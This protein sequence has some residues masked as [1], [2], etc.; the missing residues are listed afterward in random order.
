MASTVAIKKLPKSQI[1]LEGEIPAADF[2]RAVLRSLREWNEKAEIP[3]FRSGKIPENILVEKIGMSA[4]LERAAELALGDAYPK[5][6]DEQKID[7]VGQPAVTITKM[8]RG[9]ALGFK[10]ITAVVPDVALPDD[11]KTIAQ[12]AAAKNT[13]PVS[14]EEKD[15]EDA[16]DYLR[17]ANTP[18]ETPDKKPGLD[19]AF[20]QKV[21]QATL[22]D[23][24]NL[25][26]QNI[27]TDKERKA[28]DKKRMASLDAVASATIIEIPDALIDGE[29]K[30]MTEELKHSI[31]DMGLPWDDYLKH[32][33]KTESDL[34]SEWKPEAE[35][36]VRY[37]LVIRAI[38]EREHIEPSEADVGAHVEKMLARY[39]EPERAQIDKARL[40]VYA[41]GILRNEKVFELLEKS[42]P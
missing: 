39:P 16:L 3:G 14:V 41:Y 23:L 26:A 28:A 17:S 21:G 8:A 35:R 25:L 33:K 34:V 5:I 6:L 30:K 1:E 37:G 12:N 38:A 40:A 10:A 22:A 4:I 9:N 27:R 31:S 24:K 11:Y 15:I 29:R 18:K 2:D 20:A 42:A 36:R 32:I 7:A 13:E 19:D